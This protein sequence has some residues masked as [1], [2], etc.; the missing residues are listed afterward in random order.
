MATC[1]GCGGTIGRDCFNPQECEW[2]S[3]QQ[4]AQYMAQQYAPDTS[5]LEQRMTALEGKIGSIEQAVKTLV[6]Q[7]TGS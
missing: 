7:L 3:R 2:I 6:A 1:N 5:E 4:E